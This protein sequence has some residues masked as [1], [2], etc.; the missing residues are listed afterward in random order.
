MKPIF[1]LLVLGLAGNGWV[2]GACWDDYSITSDDFMDHSRKFPAFSSA[3]GPVEGKL[4]RVPGPKKWSS[5]RVVVTNPRDFQ[6]HGVTP[7]P[8]FTVHQDLPTV[9]TKIWSWMASQPW[10]KPHTDV[11]FKAHSRSS[12][13]PSVPWPVGWRAAGG[14]VRPQISILLLAFVSTNKGSI[15]LFQKFQYWAAALTLP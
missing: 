14:C 3:P 12:G 6:W 8:C 1:D 5:I 2:A 15:V 9:S 13:A 4:G 10:P 11:S 7:G